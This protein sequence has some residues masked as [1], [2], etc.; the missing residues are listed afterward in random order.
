MLPLFPVRGG[1]PHG[2]N[3]VVSKI[4]Q[5]TSVKI[6][7]YEGAPATICEFCNTRLEDWQAF[8]EQCVGT[9]EYLKTT[10][11]SIFCPSGTYFPGEP[12]TATQGYDQQTPNG[13]TIFNTSTPTASVPAA[14]G[15][16]YEV[17][18]DDG[19]DLLEPQRHQPAQVQQQNQ[20]YDE[21]DYFDEYDNE[22][23]STGPEQQ[24]MPV[25]K[26][27]NGVRVP[28][29]SREFGAKLNTL[30]HVVGGDRPHQCKVCRKRFLRRPHC[31]RHV[32]QAHPLEVEEV[33]LTSN[34]QTSYR[35][36]FYTATAPIQR[37]ME[38]VPPSPVP[39]EEQYDPTPDRPHQCEVCKKCFKRVQHLR[40]HKT[41]HLQIEI[42]RSEI[43]RGIYDQQKAQQQLETLV[44]QSPQETS[45]TNG[46]SQ[47]KAA[48]EDDDVIALSDDDDDEPVG[49][50]DDMGEEISP[51]E[52]NG[53]AHFL[54]PVTVT[55]NV[56]PEIEQQPE[57]KRPRLSDIPHLYD[58]GDDDDGDILTKNGTIRRR[59]PPMEK[60]PGERPYQCKECNKT[61]KRSD[62]LKS[63]LKTHTEATEFN[64]EYCDKG[65]RYRQ[66]FL[67]HM[68][69]KTCLG[70][71]SNRFQGHMMT[72]T[73]TPSKEE[74]DFNEDDDVVL[75]D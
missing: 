50:D 26:Q 57:E 34:W 63:H 28:K 22:D 42:D 1:N 13:A 45:L 12:S 70:E 74:E 48:P 5:C 38:P 41:A 32:A 21:D 54:D 58:S 27:H 64:C 17:L 8:R 62:H 55:A 49:D 19:S 2:P 36:R 52:F 18:M 67:I 16:N 59:A 4:L 24:V 25:M 3:T 75:G 46:V 66:N 60:I 40:R 39:R 65:F 15:G 29:W 33:K 20:T 7:H 11:R 61:F 71:R 37:V 44:P 68:K 14:D 53:F 10:Y 47:S 69:N 23:D 51:E 31:R 43:M 35:R 72:I 30:L 56:V 73:P 6:E 9:D